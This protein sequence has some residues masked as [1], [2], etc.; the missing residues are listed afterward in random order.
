MAHDLQF[1]ADN[2]GDGTQ[3]LFTCTKCG[4]QIA[5]AREGD[6]FPFSTLVDG[7]WTHPENPEMWLGPCP[8]PE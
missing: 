7:A 6:G 5:F 3:V 4:A 8:E 2:Y 1:T